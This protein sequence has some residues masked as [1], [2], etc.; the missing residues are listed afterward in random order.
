MDGCVYGDSWHACLET[1]QWLSQLCLCVRLCLTVLG[2]F[3][4]HFGTLLIEIDQP[5]ALHQIITS[6][7]LR[8]QPFFWQLCK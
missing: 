5:T 4:G 2:D 8:K 3:G 1:A 7:Q 6:A